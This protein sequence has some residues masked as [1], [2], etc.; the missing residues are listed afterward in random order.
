ML[1]TTGNEG[2]TGFAVKWN[3]DGIMRFNKHGN[4]LRAL[5]RLKTFML[6]FATLNI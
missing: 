1:S 4:L 5:A 2:V 3:R 6:I